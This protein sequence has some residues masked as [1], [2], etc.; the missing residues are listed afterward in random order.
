MD[1]R[2]M[3]L[4]V[5]EV[6]DEEAMLRFDSVFGILKTGSDVEQRRRRVEKRGLCTPPNM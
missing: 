1:S 2:T 3:C 4:Y 6:L 5:E